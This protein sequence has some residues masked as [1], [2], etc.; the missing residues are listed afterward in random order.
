MLVLSHER[1]V[2]EWMNANK[3][4]LLLLRAITTMMMY[5]IL[6]PMP[7]GCSQAA[8]MFL[9]LHFTITGSRGMY[10][11]PH[12]DIR[13][14]WPLRGGNT[15]DL[16]PRLSVG[17]HITETN[18]KQNSQRHWPTFGPRQRTPLTLRLSAT[19]GLAHTTVM[20]ASWFS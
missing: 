20:V 12:R 18:E 8:G 14:R 6:C 10:L 16:F 19:S 7:T 11:F 13:L 9:E 2:D 3:L 5:E 17:D 15:D 1:R 4:L